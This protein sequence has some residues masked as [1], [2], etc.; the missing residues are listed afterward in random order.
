M[1]AD[2]GGAREEVRGRNAGV[3]VIPCLGAEVIPCLGAEVI[4]CLGVEVIPCLGAEVT[5][6]VILFGAGLTEEREDGYTP[7]LQ[8]TLR[9]SEALQPVLRRCLCY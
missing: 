8:C 3:E 7:L 9:L 1:A 4:P 5:L 6:L 2:T